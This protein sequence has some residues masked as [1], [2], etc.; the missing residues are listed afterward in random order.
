MSLTR[1]IIESI[2][3]FGKTNSG[4]GYTRHAF[5]NADMDARYWLIEFL[6]S[7]GF[8]AH[9]DGAGNMVG[10]WECAEISQSNPIIMTGSHTDT[11]TNGG[12]FD[13]TLGVAAGIASILELRESG[14]EPD[15]AV[16]VV[17]FADEEGRFGGMLGS[18]A[19]SGQVTQEWIEN[20]S[21][22]DGVTLIEAMKAQGLEA[23]LALGCA[24]NSNDVRAFFELH[25]EQGP[26][27]ERRNQDIGIATHISGVCFLSVT[28]KGLAN[29]SG[30]TPMTDRQD[31]MVAVAKII[32]AFE[33]LLAEY[34][35][36]QTRITVGKIELLPN[37]PHT[38]PGQATFTIILREVCGK[39]LSELKERVEALVMRFAAAG[40][41][42]AEVTQK[43]WL[44][45]VT[46]DPDL[47]PLMQ[48]AA[49][50]VTP[51]HMTMVSGAGHDAQSMQAICAS[52]LI[53]IPSRLGISHSPKEYSSWE[54]IDQGAQVLKQ[55]IKAL[56]P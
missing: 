47:V 16:E 49:D 26:V 5:S 22:A 46:L 25:I 44:D 36:D 12:A 7:E 31:P 15:C 48:K 17:S 50:L 32:C 43:S 39:R 9:L 21:D 56:L 40:N 20:A 6:K 29:H 34:G 1:H 28:L 3:Q 37:A 54:Q 42:T 18:Q 53:F 51:N 4:G 10:R 30:T 52:A 14:I 24:R 41:L 35:T 55:A 38:I 2:N 45:P 11:V 23:H 33:P 13:G 8:A 27:L 19:I